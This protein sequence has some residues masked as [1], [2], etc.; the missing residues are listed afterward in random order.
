[1]ALVIQMSCRTRM[2]DETARHYAGNL[3]R[4]GY[5]AKATPATGALP[6]ARISPEWKDLV[7]SAE[8][9]GTALA[10]FMNAKDDFVAIYPKDKQ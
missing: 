10:L 1:M 8:N 9:L 7:A 4:A 3:I 5:G 2:S 6:P